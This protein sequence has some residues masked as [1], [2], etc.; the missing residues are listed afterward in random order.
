MLSRTAD[1]GLDVSAMVVVQD[2]FRAAAALRSRL[3]GRLCRPRD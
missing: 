2:I 1:S 3:E